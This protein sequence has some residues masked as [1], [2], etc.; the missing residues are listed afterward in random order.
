MF[1]VEPRLIEDAGEDPV[2]PV[3]RRRPAFAGLWRGAPNPPRRR[4]RHLA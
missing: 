4:R 3:F 1:L 2:G